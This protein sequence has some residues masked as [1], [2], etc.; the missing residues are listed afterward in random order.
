MDD[1]TKDMDYFL[2][3]LLPDAV[4]NGISL[5]FAEISET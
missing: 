2:I 1:S 4:L 5:I 3:L